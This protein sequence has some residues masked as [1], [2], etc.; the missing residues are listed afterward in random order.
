M[1]KHWIQTASGRMFDLLEPDPDLFDIEEI[2][3]SLSQLCRFTGHT[4]WFMSVAQHSVIVSLLVPSEHAFAG[5]MHDAS[6]AYV[7]DV[8]RP[9][10]RLL[11]DYMAIEDKIL[12]AIGQR[13]G[14]SLPLPPEVKV[15][16][17]IS[18]LWE[19]RDL[20]APPP[21]EWAE[22]KVLAL[23]PQEVLRPMAPLQAQ[24][25]FM[26]RFTSLAAR[27]QEDA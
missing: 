17:N 25:Y 15:A 1:S 2:A 22:E 18:L 10:K 26:D 14:F 12:G 19:R 3:H 24:Q 4:R 11:P 9:L 7:G 21:K 5:L 20:M 16:D 13:Y 23:V 8:A 27:R 6:E